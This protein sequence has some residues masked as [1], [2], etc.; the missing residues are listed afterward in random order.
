M[1]N[2]PILHRDATINFNTP[3]RYVV[4]VFLWRSYYLTL[5]RLW[6]WGCSAP[7]LSSTWAASTASSA[8][9][10]SRESSPKQQTR[11]S[12]TSIPTTCTTNTH[13]HTHTSQHARVQMHRRGLHWQNTVFAHFFSRPEIWVFQDPD[14]SSACCINISSSLIQTTLFA[15]TWFNTFSRLWKFV[16][17]VKTTHNLLVLACWRNVI[18]TLELILVNVYLYW[19]VT[20]CCIGEEQQLH[21]LMLQ[22][23]EELF[24][25]LVCD[26]RSQALYL[27]AFRF[28]SFKVR[29]QDMSFWM[30]Q[31]ESA[32]LPYL[33]CSVWGFLKELFTCECVY[34]YLSA[35]P[36]AFRWPQ[37]LLRVHWTE[38]WVRISHCGG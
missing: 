36:H 38:G 2:R 11:G 23:G 4:I 32:T 9:A 7:S 29:T 26:V 37:G 5:S 16:A 34:V 8:A 22:W 24:F 15:L 30:K 19:D 14:H 3:N 33:L 1:Q 27:P 18:S 25:W 17:L 28:L 35:C 13:T 31:P 20:I 21:F 10:W 6:R 12:S